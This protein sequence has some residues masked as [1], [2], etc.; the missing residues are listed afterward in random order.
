MS[1]VPDVTH[2]TIILSSASTTTALNG[3]SSSDEF[4]QTMYNEQNVD[5]GLVSFSFLIKFN[6]VFTVH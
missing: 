2:E 4:E 6:L 1:P 3:I 5:L